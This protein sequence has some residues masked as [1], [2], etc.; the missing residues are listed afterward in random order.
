MFQHKELKYHRAPAPTDV[1][2]KNLA[3]PKKRRYWYRLVTIIISLFA[4]GIDFGLMYGL[5]KWAEDEDSSTFSIFYSIIRSLLVAIIN[6]ALCNL[7]RFLSTFEKHHTIAKFHVWI[8][9]KLSAVMF[10][11]TGIVPF[12]VNLNPKYGWFDKGGLVENATYNMVM[13]SFLTPLTTLISPM[14]ILKLLRQYF[15]ERKGEDSQ[16]TQRQA[17]QLFEAPPIDLPEQYANT[18]LLFCM[19]F[20]YAFL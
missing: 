3:I 14:Y 7:V 13:I 9:I 10:I 1:F 19:T 16:M 6:F 15:E 12:F 17:N 20:F 5:E 18:I 8:T 11:N 2:W 4:I